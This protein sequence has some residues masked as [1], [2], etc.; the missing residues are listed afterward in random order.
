MSYHDTSKLYWLSTRN[1]KKLNLRIL[2]YKAHSY[3]DSYKH[4][5]SIKAQFVKK[6]TK[7]NLLIIYKAY[8]RLQTMTK[9]S[10]K[11][12][13]NRQKKRSCAHKIPSTCINSLWSKKWLS[14]F[15]WKSDKILS[16]DYIQKL[17]ITSDHDLNTHKF[18]KELAKNCRK[19]GIHKIVPFC[20]KSDKKMHIFRPWTKHL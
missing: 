12:Q 7:H 20:E 13:N 15:L 10:V 11:F 9:T 4:L 1:R 18:S 3:P 14:S 5:Q 19:S 2:Y 6:I 17:C 16:E 8:A